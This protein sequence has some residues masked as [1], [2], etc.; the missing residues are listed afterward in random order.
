MSIATALELAQEQA[1]AERAGLDARITDL[2]SRAAL[3]GGNDLDDW[4]TR[5]DL[6][7]RMLSE[8]DA[9][10]RRGQERVT[11]LEQHISEFRYFKSEL[12]ERFP[13]MNLE[14]VQTRSKLIKMTRVKN[15]YVAKRA[16][17][18]KSRGYQA[19]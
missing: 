16:D 19:N 17:E 11:I 9:E 8:S 7:S 12:R 13:E 5:S 6:C 2:V 10:I 1:E 18:N 14:P 4:L 3:A 15:Q